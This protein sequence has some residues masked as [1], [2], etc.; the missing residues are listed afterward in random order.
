M[1]DL[2][3]PKKW[4]KNSMRVSREW[5]EIVAKCL[6]DGL[7]SGNY[8]PEYRQY[9]LDCIYEFELALEADDAKTQNKN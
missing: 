8:K 4:A 7:N 5:A 1:K 2:M 9:I 6:C 3:S